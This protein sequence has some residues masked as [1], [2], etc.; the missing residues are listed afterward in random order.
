MLDRLDYM[1]KGGR[2]SAVTAL[3]ANL[4]KLKPCIEV[5]DGR[6]SV[7]KKYRGTFEK[8]IR[9]YAEERLRGR[10]DLQKDMVFITHTPTAENVV[11]AVRE[12]VAS[13]ADFAETFETSAGCTISCHCGPSTLGVLFIRK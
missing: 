1:R 8:C 6:M 2:C 4:L 12:A 11:Q 5:K 9:Q 13:S 7:G 3:G 10:E